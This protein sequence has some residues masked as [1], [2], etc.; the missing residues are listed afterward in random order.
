MFFRLSRCRCPA[1]GFIRSGKPDLIQRI[2]ND[3]LHGVF[4]RLRC[5]DQPRMEFH[6]GPCLRLGRF[7]IHHRTLPCCLYGSFYK[8]LYYKRMKNTRCILRFYVF[9]V[10]AHESTGFPT[11]SVR[12]VRS[13][14]TSPPRGPTHPASGRTMRQTRDPVSGIPGEYR[15]TPR[16]PGHRGRRMYAWQMQVRRV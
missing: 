13:G 11:Y 9:F 5:P 16:I 2:A 6:K 4:F 8:G 14:G 15:Y 10:H 1:T 3:F 12:S 7:L